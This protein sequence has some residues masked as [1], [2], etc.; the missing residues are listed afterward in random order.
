M[1]RSFAYLVAWKYPAPGA[2]GNVYG[3]ALTREQIAAP[4]S[5]SGK[6]DPDITIDMK[7]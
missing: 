6:I 7:L 5:R 3:P 2:A 4:P 1:M